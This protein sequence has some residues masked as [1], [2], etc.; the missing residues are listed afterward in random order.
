KVA[1]WGEVFKIDSRE[2]RN[3]SGKIFS[4]YITDYTSS[5]IL[6]LVL[7]MKDAA[8]IEGIK[9]GET[10]IASG[11]ASFDK[12]DKEVNIRTFN[13][14]RVKKKQRSD[15]S[16][17][18]RVELHAH[19][20]MSTMDGLVTAK[21]LVKTAAKFG[22]KAI[23]ITDH[24]VVQAFPEA[25]AA[26][27]DAAKAGTPIK[28]LYGVEG[29]LVNDRIPVVTGDG[30]QSL[31]NDTLIVF[32]LE[33][34]GLSAATERIIEIGAVKIKGGEIIE[35]FDIFVDP[36]QKLSPEI[37]NLTHITD[38]MLVGAPSESEALDKFYEFCG[39][40]NA[41][42]IAHNAKFD[43]SFIKVAARRCG[44]GYNF[45]VVDTL[46]LAR[47]VFKEL[48]S[49]KLGKLAEHLKIGEFQ[50]HR[51]CDDA[52]ALALIF[53]KMVE[54]IKKKGDVEFV[55]DLNRTL[56]NVDF[57]KVP[58]Y[59]IIIL[60]KN[61]IGLKNLYKIIS[62]SHVTNFYKTPRILKS[63]IDKWRE[64]LIIGSACE[65]GE[66]FRT[67]LDGAQFNELCEIAKFYDFLEVQPIGNNAFMLRK[68]ICKSE[69]DLR[70]FNRTIVRIGD[71]LGLP[72][73]ATGDVHFLNP[74]DS[75]YRAI[76]M[77][78][79]GFDDADN[80]APLYFKTTD[81]MLEEFSYLGKE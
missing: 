78:G 21:D 2:M 69:E 15:K 19:T 70:D 46:I 54:N 11:E 81:E 60:V 55:L 33:T 72:V 29:Y 42:L 73:C 17:A 20:K 22:H 12:Y 6:K 9:K 13:I 36:E 52:R 16:E 18:K 64:G 41:V 38:E 4:I 62:E 74:E 5:N 53:F 50:A 43:T 79:L 31:D 71:H 1:V 76:L 57:K 65:A 23:A 26:A 35:E 24:S 58:S 61:L 75:V 80:Q 37:V 3:G 67:M 47:A 27:K 49:F 28:I 63:N 77:A 48:K 51:A 14:S 66:L 40:D 56:E 34:T 30:M 45:T 10:L 39:G 44:K 68:G 8:I 25:A 59:H 7:D 32:D